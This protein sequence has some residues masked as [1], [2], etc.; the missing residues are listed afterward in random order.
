MF[1]KLLNRHQK[2]HL[3]N[4]ATNFVTAL[5][6]LFFYQHLIF[7]FIYCSF[8][9]LHLLFACL[10]LKTYWTSLQVAFGLSFLGFYLWYHLSFNLISIMLFMLSGACSFFFVKGF[11]G[12]ARFNKKIRDRAL[13][14]LM[15][16]L[17]TIKS[18]SKVKESSP[19]DEEEDDEGKG[20]LH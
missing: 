12:D 11:K 10:R 6:F 14:N 18:K 5:F 4:A 9:C 2:N 16:S 15:Q 20:W 7:S 13:L 3:I 8:S 19:E 1:F 17:Q